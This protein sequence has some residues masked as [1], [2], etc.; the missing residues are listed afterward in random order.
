MNQIDQSLDDI[1]K[2]QRLDNKKLK[3]KGK[4]T[5]PA[6]NPN[7]GV[8]SKGIFTKG[9]STKG[10]S[11]KGAKIPKQTSGGIPPRTGI[12]T[13]RAIKAAK[14][15]SP[16]AEIFTAGYIAKPTS[17]IKLFT[18]NNKAGI[19]TGKQLADTSKPLSVGPLR[20]VTT[21]KAKQAAAPAA[22]PTAPASFSSRN[23]RGRVAP[24]A[25]AQSGGFRGADTSRVDSGSISGANS[26]H[27][28]NERN[29]DR[30]QQDRNN[31]RGFDR[32]NDRSFDRGNDRSNDRGNDRNFDRNNDRNFDRS[33]DRGDDRSVD[34][35]NV[36]RVASDFIDNRSGSG[37][38]LQSSGR[39]NLGNNSS[40]DS[41]NYNHSNFSA[42][43]NSAYNNMSSSNVNGGH[44]SSNI[45]RRVNESRAPV[46]ALRQEGRLQAPI[47]VAM[48]MAMDMDMD[49]EQPDEMIS[50]KGSA[51]GSS[52]AFRGES[53]PVTIEIENLDPGTT[54]EDV[55]YVCS[56]FGEILSCVCSH[57]FSQVTYAR[58]VAGQAAVDNLH[59]KKADNGKVLR[60]TMLKNPI[61]HQDFNTPAA[62]VPTPIAGPMKLLTKA[63]HGTITN[64]GTI[65][66]DHLLA[67]QTMLKVQQHRMAQLHQEEERIKSLRLQ[68]GSQQG[69]IG[70]LSTPSR[71]YF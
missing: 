21:Q 60:V 63:V 11:T 68:A 44:Q 51:P 32:N 29:F 24:T 19:S 14:A 1:I 46:Q 62:H 56:R 38:G 20:L 16:Y 53:G 31:D 52:V 6:G 54:S 30:A 70:S 47:P 42:N 12:R 55:K 4:P 22:T 9:I 65:Y 36:R 5:A 50:I 33:N 25:S 28:G 57:G 40:S 15:H 34:R 35:P 48:D 2:Q 67:A 18:T 23:D 3:S 45:Q 10:I 8:S 49:M 59:G 41:Y 27:R 64:A 61:M 58:K 39:G 7:K 69:H 37:S 26:N 66:S 17:T 13:E 71:G 43:Q